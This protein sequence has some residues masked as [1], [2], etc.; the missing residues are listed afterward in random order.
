LWNSTGT[1]VES[2]SVVA[3]KG[4]INSDAAEGL[5]ITVTGSGW[6]SYSANKNE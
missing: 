6:K 1:K 2:V 5:D 3:H 4:G